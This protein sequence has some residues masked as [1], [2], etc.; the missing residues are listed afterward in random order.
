MEPFMGIR[1]QMGTMRSVMLGMLLLVFVP[2]LHA[3]DVTITGTVYD[4]DTDEPLPGVNILVKGTSIGT[5]SDEKGNFVE[6]VPTLTDTLVLSFVGY[7]TR[8]IPINGRTEISVGLQPQVFSEE[9]MVVV[10]YAEQKREHLTGA[11]QSINMDEVEDLPVGDLATAIKGKLP[12][13]NI[14]G[15]SVCPGNKPVMSI[16]NPFTLSKDGGNNLPL[17][18]IDGVLQIGS[19]GQNDNT[20]F[21][22]L[23]P[24]EVESIS[25]LKDAAAA[26]YG[27]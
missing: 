14:S 3:Q 25:V 18:V 13:V 19:Q 2:A 4:S 11:V 5:A 7:E 1:N 9:E 12:G 21:N 22:T 17:Y 26:V 20:L 6:N 8:E 23:V 15:E 24:S 10:G 27:S 16:R